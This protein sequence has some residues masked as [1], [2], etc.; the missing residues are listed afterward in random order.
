MPGDRTAKI[1][2]DGVTYTIHAFNI[3]EMRRVAKLISN[4]SGL[5]G[6]EQAIEIVKMALARAEPKLDLE[7]FD[8][9]EPQF[10]QVTAT[11]NAILELAG[12]KATGNPPAGEAGAP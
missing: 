5:D 8:E 6:F 2:F 12:L 10:D 7:K 4:G 1:I 3:G 9:M 11:S